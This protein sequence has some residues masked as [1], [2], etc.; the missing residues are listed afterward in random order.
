MLD[1]WQVTNNDCAKAEEVKA[2]MMAT[3]N[4]IIIFT[5]PHSTLC[6]RLL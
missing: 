2:Q 1:F 3:A 6:G 4:K 5:I